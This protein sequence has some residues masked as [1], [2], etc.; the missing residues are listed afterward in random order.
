MKKTSLIFGGT[1]GIGW[2]I[3]K[4]LVKRGDKV[5]VASRNIKNSKK[6]ISVDLED[7]IQDESF[8]KKNRIK[9]IDNI[10][11]SQRYR[12][13]IPGSERQIMLSSTSRLID[14]LQK[15]MSKKATIVVIGSVCSDGVILDQNLEYH[16]TRGGLEQLIKF[17]A[18]KLGKKG[19]RIN[20]ILATRSLKKENRKF[21][22]K[23]N[24]QI[25]KTLERITPL[26]R[27][28]DAKDI[29]N[30]VE[31]LSSDKSAYITGQSIKV[32]GGLSLINQEHILYI[33]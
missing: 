3:S 31:F 15:K 16:T 32:D 11:F 17:K 12:G 14:G 18:I 23:K 1:K 25:R 27:M 26:G 33:K 9:K 2:E 10:I 28:S 7:H 6:I 30:T 8:I 29:A 24:N 13:N 19:V 20:S 4:T 22:L 21:Y 5:I